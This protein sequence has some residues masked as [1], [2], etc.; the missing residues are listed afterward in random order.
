MVYQPIPQRPP[1]RHPRSTEHLALKSNSIEHQ[2]RSRIRRLTVAVRPHLHR[3]DEIPTFRLSRSP[4]FIQ[5]ERELL[6]AREIHRN[7]HAVVVRSFRFLVLRSKDHHKRRA[8]RAFAKSAEGNFRESAAVDGALENIIHRQRFPV[9]P[10]NSGRPIPRSI[11]IQHSSA[12]TSHIQRLIDPLDLHRNVIDIPDHFRR[13]EAVKPYLRRNRALRN[14]PTADHQT[15]LPLRKWSPV[16]ARFTYPFPRPVEENHI[17]PQRIQI[18]ALEITPSRNP[19]PLPGLD[20]H[21]LRIRTRS[22]LRPITISDPQRPPATPRQIARDHGHPIV[23]QI[24]AI[25]RRSLPI[26]EPRQKRG[27]PPI[28]H[29]H[30]CQDEQQPKNSFHPDSIANLPNRAN[31]RIPDSTDQM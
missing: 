12:P 8:R 31:S 15:P 9:I 18:T 1:Y 17:H 23:P 16:S 10:P 3:L 27:P 20:H 5:R 14:N 13:I 30:Q 19:H 11:R 7:L 29:T 22:Q 6:P 28:S 25:W 4:E 26:L 2:L 21:F 24:P